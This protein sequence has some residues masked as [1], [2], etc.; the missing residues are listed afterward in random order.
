MFKEIGI[1]ILGFVENMSYFQPKG[2]SEQFEIFGRG[3]GKRLAEETQVP[4][5][6]EI[7]LDADV[8][9][10]GDKGIPIVAADPDC[11]VSQAF[12]E[13]AKKVAAQISIHSLA[14]VS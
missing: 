14:T 12:L 4:F 8:R 2:S 6:G 3:G 9:I 5:L 10:G 7:P 11:A 1:P 13:I